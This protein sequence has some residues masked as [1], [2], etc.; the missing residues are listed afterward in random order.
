MNRALTRAECSGWGDPHR[1]DLQRPGRR[2]ND[3]P[4]LRL[5]LVLACLVFGVDA[6]R[7]ETGRS[8][9]GAIAARTLRFDISNGA[10]VMGEGAS[11]LEGGLTL[12]LG[13]GWL[14]NPYVLLRAAVGYAIVVDGRGPVNQGRALLE[15]ALRLGPQ[16]VS[17]LLGAGGAFWN[18][19]PSAHALAGLAFRVSTSW[20]LGIDVR[21]GPCWDRTSR[22]RTLTP[23]GEPQL[24]MSVWFH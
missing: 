13:V 22:P 10:I 2:R 9:K 5:V 1:A 20:E 18:E 14:P 11:S 21:A 23:Y 15:G 4:V 7:A 6:A 17:F 3:G 8:S 12:D 24:R 19:S 16:R